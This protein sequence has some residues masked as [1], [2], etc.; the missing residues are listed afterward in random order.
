MSFFPIIELVDR[1]SIAKLKFYKT[2]CNQA[3]LDFYAAELSVYD[4]TDIQ[5]EL[6]QLYKIHQHIWNL[7]AELK[8]GCEN[9]LNLSEIGRRA[10]AIRDYNNKRV[11]LKNNIAEKLGCTVREIK[12]DHL[13]Q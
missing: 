12:K 9:L 10:I 1:Y 5:L 13:S 2:Q 8:S 4:L 7:E 6:E 3:E 11:A